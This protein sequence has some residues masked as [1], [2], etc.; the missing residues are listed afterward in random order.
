MAKN[1]TWVF[2]NL[3]S[4][5]LHRGVTAP[6]KLKFILNLFEAAV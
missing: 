4:S 2:T 5:V 3:M 1:V 6:R